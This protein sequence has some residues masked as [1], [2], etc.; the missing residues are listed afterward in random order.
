MVEMRRVALLTVLLLLAVQTSL[1]LSQPPEKTDTE[2]SRTP[3]SEYMTNNL[4][5]VNVQDNRHV[6][7][8]YEYPGTTENVWWGIFYVY[9]DGL[10]SAYDVGDYPLDTPL[11]VV[12]TDPNKVCYFITDQATDSTLSINGTFRMYGNDHKWVELV[13]E[14]TNVGGSQITGLKLYYYEDFYIQG[15]WGDEYGRTGTVDTGTTPNVRW[16][17][18]VDSGT[19]VY[20]GFMPVY[21]AAM[22]A[23]TFTMHYMVDYYWD[24]QTIVESGGDLPD[25]VDTTNAEDSAA[26]ME[27]VVGT[28][29]PGESVVVSFIS[30]VGDN[31]ADF[32]SELVD[33]FDTTSPRQ[34]PGP[35][36]E[37]IWPSLAFLFT[38]IVAVYFSKQ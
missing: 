17:G 14:V 19:G 29:D 34:P 38:L 31:E 11:T 23:Q 3:T 24:V 13:F 16:V 12:G 18:A 33:G 1:I 15:T 36:A 28:L 20:K 5:S 21:G 37:F 8:D 30:A 4:I 9:H 27:F 7:E 22:Y 32:T 25:T 6:I 10:T 2:V 26:A 35:V